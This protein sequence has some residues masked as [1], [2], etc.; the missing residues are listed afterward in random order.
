M[1]F[2]FG[3][4]MWY[5]TPYSLT[6]H[7]SQQRRD[8]L[9]FSLN[10]GNHGGA[11]NMAGRVLSRFRGAVEGVGK[12]MLVKGSSWPTGRRAGWAEPST[13]TARIPVQYG[14]TDQYGCDSDSDRYHNRWHK[15]PNFFIYIFIRTVFVQVKSGCKGSRK[16]GKSC[17]L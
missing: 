2:Q 16:R 9:I 6:V 15:I 1:Q 8:N 13:I 11:R 10:F 12:F 17:F 4:G 7:D 3:A 14:C 5:C